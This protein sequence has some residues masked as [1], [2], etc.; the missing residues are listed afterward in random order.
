[1]SSSTLS[2]KLRKRTDPQRFVGRKG[3]LETI[4][5]IGRAKTRLEQLWSTISTRGLSIFSKWPVVVLAGKAFFVPPK[6]CKGL[7]LPFKIHM[8]GGTTADLAL[9]KKG[10]ISG[11]SIT[12]EGQLRVNAHNSTDEV[13]H[14]TPKTVMVNVWADQLEIRYLGQKPKVLSIKKK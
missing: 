5:P 13:I 10:L 1:M 14:L 11:L 7:Y 9:Q 4:F 3:N 8:S 12:K 2:K 6:I